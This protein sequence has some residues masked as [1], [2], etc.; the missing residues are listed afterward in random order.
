MN[1]DHVPARRAVEALRSGVP[2]RDVVRHIEPAQAD[3]RKAFENL[4]QRAEDGWQSGKFPSGLL[5][6]GDFGTG[7]SHWLEYCRHLAL[8]NGFVVSPVTLSKETPLH[9]LNKV[10][11]AAVE[12]AAVHGR[13]GPA[14]VEIA[15]T[16]KA[17]TAPGHGALTAWVEDNRA[18][19][20]RFAATLHLFAQ[21]ADEELQRQI[22]DE[23]AGYPMAVPALKAAL[24]DAGKLGVYPVARP[25]PGQTLGRFEFLARFFRA[26]G[27]N[28]WVLLIDET[29]MVSRY[30]LRQRGRAYAHLAQLMGVAQGGG[31]G[32]AVPGVAAVF[33]ITKDYAGQ[34]LYGRKND[35]TNV[36]ARM[37]GS[38]DDALTAPAQ[39]GM[40]A[41]K[42]KAL[43]LR[44]PTA[45][46]VAEVYQKV[47]ALYTQ[48]YAWPAPDIASPREYAATT[49]MRQYIRA[50]ITT[51]DLRRLYGL[52]SHIETEAVAMDYREDPD[53][54]A[55]APPDE[56]YTAL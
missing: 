32:G 30:S 19:D 39:A 6:E 17:A 8:D 41:I 31:P 45:A 49:S 36:P 52:A 22:L 5:L 26:A 28:G 9:D 18:I 47:R 15:H 51:W 43:E 11:R 54:Q 3:L 21:S 25:I 34:V 2:N 33:T 46:Q 7:K 55:E 50:W 4:L 29:E 38:R 27:Y 10:Y 1:P 12:A 20:A 44:S 24:R 48:A 37:Q 40:N 42:G 53:L 14:L 56:P 16:Y 13:H 23:W 35:M